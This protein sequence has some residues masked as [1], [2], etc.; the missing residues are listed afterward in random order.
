MPE[1]VHDCSRP[2]CKERAWC[3]PVLVVPPHPMAVAAF[4]GVRSVLWLPL[5]QRHFS[6]T[7]IDEVLNV[8]AVKGMQESITRDF[9]Q[10]GSIP[11]WKAAKFQAL[12]S[13]TT[14]F[15]HYEQQQHDLREGKV[16]PARSVH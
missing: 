10:N 6:S 8:E 1:R 14:E 2:G 16:L 3:T 7:T 12:R 11:D 5:C 13:Y 9:R 4:A 15:A